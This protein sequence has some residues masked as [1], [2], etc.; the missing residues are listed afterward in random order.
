MTQD[1]DLIISEGGID[2]QDAL[3]EILHIASELHIVPAS[4][5]EFVR[6]QARTQAL[7]LS[8]QLD[9]GVRFVDLRVMRTSG[10]WRV[11]CFRAKH[12]ALVNLMYC[13]LPVASYVADQANR[14]GLS[15]SA[16]RVDD[17]Q[18]LGNCGALVVKT[19]Q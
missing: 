4:V 2:D 14:D 8:Q 7:T 17:C 15:G 3:A 11:R 6:L 5:M 1:L 13:C 19:R 12:H 16:A 18:P 9:A 10:E